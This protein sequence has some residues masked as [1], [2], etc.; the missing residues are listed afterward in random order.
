MGMIGVKDP[1]QAPR[2]LSAGTADRVINQV[3]WERVAGAVD[4]QA[5]LLDR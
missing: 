2:A 1:K 4:E 3:N 5:I